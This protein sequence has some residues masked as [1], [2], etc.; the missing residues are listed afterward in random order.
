MIDME[1]I[2]DHSEDDD[3]LTPFGRMY[4]A[5]IC[6]FQSQGIKMSDELIEEIRKAAI[7]YRDQSDALEVL[8]NELV[9]VK[10]KLTEALEKLAESQEKA[11]KLFR[12]LESALK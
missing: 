3:G 8:N 10:G 5:L 2:N 11:D 9:E 6:E 7:S 12:M 4:V 1:M